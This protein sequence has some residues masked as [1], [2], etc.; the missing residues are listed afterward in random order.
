VPIRA[1]SLPSSGAFFPKT[2]ANIS[3]N[4]SSPLVLLLATGG[5]TAAMAWM[6]QPLVDE[7]FYR[8]RYDLVPWISGAVAPPSSSSAASRITARR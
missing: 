6:M 4:T 7:I 3:L 2:R 5:A 1:R 8:E